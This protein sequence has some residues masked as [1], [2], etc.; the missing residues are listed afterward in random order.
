MR[1]FCLVMSVFL[2][3]RNISCFWGGALKQITTIELFLDVRR[4]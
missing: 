1:I 3:N 2:L 4:R